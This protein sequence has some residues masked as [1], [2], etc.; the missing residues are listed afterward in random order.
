[1]ESEK[2]IEVAR[3]RLDT[4]TIAWHAIHKKRK[5]LR[6]QNWEDIYQEF[7]DA[8]KALQALVKDVHSKEIKQES[9][10]KLPDTA[11]SR[12]VVPPGLSEASSTHPIDVEKTES[13]PSTS[14]NIVSAAITQQPLSTSFT[15]KGASLVVNTKL[16]VQAVRN[17]LNTL[18]LVQNAPITPQM[19]PEAL[20]NQIA[21]G[22][23][24]ASATEATGTMLPTTTLQT[25]QAAR[26]E[27]PESTPA[28]LTLQTPQ[29]ARSEP[30]EST[31]A[32]P[33]LQTPQAARSEPPE[34]TPAPVT[35]QTPQAAH[36]EPPES[37]RAPLT[38]QTSQ[39]TH[40][41]PPQ[42]TP[43]LSTLHT[44][45]AT[46]SEPSAFVPEPT[47]LLKPMKTLS[48]PVGT[49]L[50]T[51]MPQTS[52]T[53]QSKS[54]A[55]PL[56]LSTLFKPDDMLSRTAGTLRTND[57][58]RLMD[59]DMESNSDENSMRL[60]KDLAIFDIP[61]DPVLLGNDHKDVS[62]QDSKQSEIAHQ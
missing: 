31:P 16:G 49:M 10:D 18:P 34:S 50:T 19:V 25:P 40:S 55:S 59:I 24:L 28:P 27:P 9:L 45:Q 20:N 52:L 8:K 6:P 60:M 17:V 62:Q 23:L 13:T 30:P 32:L 38:L 2:S 53:A 29:A 14:T 42:S 51:G 47:T 4:A 26:S 54:P 41:E 11:A 15:T 7:K 3:N 35:P 56:A 22:N 61:I 37:T 48:G 44:P 36:S 43:A 46:H 57:G 5:E 1:M 33:T 12:I 39:A 58:P 21:H